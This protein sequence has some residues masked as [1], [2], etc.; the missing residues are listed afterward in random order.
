MGY[1]IEKKKKIIVSLDFDETYMWKDLTTMLWSCGYSGWQSQSCIEKQTPLIFSRFK[2]KCVVRNQSALGGYLKHCIVPENNVLLGVSS[3]SEFPLFIKKAIHEH[4]NEESILN[5]REKIVIA[6]GSCHMPYYQDGDG[7]RLEHPEIVIELLK[8]CKSSEEVFKLIAQTPQDSKD[9]DKF[10]LDEL[11]KVVHQHFTYMHYSEQGYSIENMFLI[12]NLASH[13]ENTRYH[14]NELM[15]NENDV[16]FSF[17][18]APENEK[19]TEYLCEAYQAVGANPP[20]HLADEIAPRQAAQNEGGSIY[21]SG[22][23]QGS[24]TPVISNEDRSNENTPQ[25]SQTFRR[26]L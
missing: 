25:Q 7:N 16:G 11:G 4:G 13:E 12:D 10:H 14:W 21:H 23:F 20:T 18:H 6:K 1:N 5:L 24:S 22:I 26:N 8:G 19:G 17:I 2:E 15:C 3:Y 9:R